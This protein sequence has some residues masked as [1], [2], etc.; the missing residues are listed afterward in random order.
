M[1]VSSRTGPAPLDL[2]WQ[3]PQGLIGLSLVNTVLSILTLGIYSFWAKTEVRKRLWSAIR[4]NG[5]PLSYTGTGKQLF[6]G[7]LFAF[8]VVF[9]P[10][11]ILFTALAIMAGP[12]SMALAIAQLVSYVAILFLWGFASWRAYRYRIA[13]T[14]W[15][16]IRGSLHGNERSY[17]LTFFFT[18][19]L[20]PLTLGWIIPWRSTKLQGLV[21]NSARFGNGSFQFNANAGPLYKPFAIFWF[22]VL[23]L[24]LAASFLL[25][26]VLAPIMVGEIDPMQEAEHQRMFLATYLGVILI[27]VP[28]YLVLSAWYRAR[29]DNYFASQTRF[30]GATLRGTQRGRGLMWASIKSFFIA[31]LTL[32]IL[33]PV[34]QA[35]LWRYWIETLHVDGTVDLDQV[36]Q[37]AED[38]LSR[39]EG[40]AQAFDFDV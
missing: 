12:E 32:G 20:I 15:R 19:L 5:E 38:R 37:G 28:I 24:V 9:L 40:L 36:A 18:G 7:F 21:V 23:G 35:I 33:A 29:R 26:G 2:S 22:L 1:D 4:L 17:A 14:T 3:P 27:G 8:A 10:L 34:A 11:L 13:N 30:D 31:L 6:L 16:G 25:F 39:G